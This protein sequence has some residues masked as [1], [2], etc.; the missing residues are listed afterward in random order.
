MMYLD[1]EA[2]TEKEAIQLALESL[3]L[4]EEDVRIEI[5]SKEKKGIFGIGK[6]EKAKIRVYYK[7]KSEISGAFETI[8]AFIKMLDPQ[9]N[10]EIVSLDS[11]QYLLKIDGI[12]SSQLIGKNGRSLEAIQNIVTAILLKQGDKYRVSV[13]VDNYKAK[14][15]GLI[16]KKAL[17]MAKQVVKTKKPILL[18]PMNSYERRLVHLEVSKKVKGVLTQS[19]GDGRIKSVKIV[20]VNS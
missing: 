5:L 6:K 20:P 7:E 12:D 2:N 9:S 17:F 15:Y 11:N 16:V 4:T 10:T 18:K 1:Y 8:K 14:R 3:G 13:D 19:E